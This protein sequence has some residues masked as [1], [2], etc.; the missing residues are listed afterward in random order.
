MCSS[1]SKVSPTDM[2]TQE[3]SHIKKMENTI[4]PRFLGLIQTGPCPESE[5]VRTLKI[6][7]N[8]VLYCTVNSLYCLA[9]I[10]IGYNMV[11]YVYEI[12]SKS[13]QP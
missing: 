8:T 13:I 1:T 11:Q 3:N 6:E 9:H 12:H 2:K 7:Y 5:K 4:S 10:L